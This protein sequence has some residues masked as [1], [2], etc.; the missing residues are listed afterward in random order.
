MLTA[1]KL[2]AVV[3]LPGLLAL[4]L[5]CGPSAPA[6]QDA[7]PSPETTAA[8]EPTPTI[9]WLNS[10]PPSE[11]ELATSAARPTMTPFPPGYVRPT[12]IPTVPPLSD[13][14]LSATLAAEIATEEAQRPPESARHKPSIQPCPRPCPRL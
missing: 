14:E 9:L 13:A 3:I 7:S 6:G 1:Y 10:T 2:I 5:A 8:P 12:H 4:A 11:S